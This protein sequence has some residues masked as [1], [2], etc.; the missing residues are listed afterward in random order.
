MDVSELCYCGLYCG[1]CASRRKISDHAD[2]FREDLQKEGYDRWY[3]HVPALRDTFRDFWKVL[4][5]LAENPCPGCRE[6][7][8]FPGCRIRP[9]ARER[10]FT[11]CIECDDYPCE[12]FGM[13][14]AYVNLMADNER[15]REI[16]LERW[17]EEQE[18]RADTGFVYSDVRLPDYGQPEGTD[19]TDTADTSEQ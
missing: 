3:E 17:I 11:T 8:G 6:G 16:G 2:Q 7:G 13:L 5:H 14:R 15:K 18:E 10:G 9:C 12:H 19:P 1:L 4:N